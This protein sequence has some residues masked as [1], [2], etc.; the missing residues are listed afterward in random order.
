MQKQ[1]LLRNNFTRNLSLGRWID[2][3]LKSINQ[4][5][6]SRYLDFI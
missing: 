4:L 6:Q 3:P 5:Q 1:K 2:I